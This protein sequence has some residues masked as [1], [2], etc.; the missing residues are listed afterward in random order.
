MKISIILIL[1]ATGLHT[2]AQDSTA[3][4]EIFSE[5]KKIDDQNNPNKDFPNKH[6]QKFSFLTTDQHIAQTQ[7]YRKQISRLLALSKSELTRQEQISRETMLLRMNNDVSFV[8]FKIYLLPFNAEGG[9]Y[10]Q[11]VFFLPRMPFSKKEDYVAYL[12][13]LPSYSV[14]IQYNH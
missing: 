2:L 11:P 8:D 14:Y 13:W 6:P 9:F 7:F 4:E 3:I 12:K 1:L 5:I 10:N